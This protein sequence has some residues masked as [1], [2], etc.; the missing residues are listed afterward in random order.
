MLH[1]HDEVVTEAEETPEHKHEHLSAL[2][3]TP[4]EYALDMPLAA[5]GYEAYR[6]KKD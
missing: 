6:Y 3:S 5:A 4:P 1:V 2:L